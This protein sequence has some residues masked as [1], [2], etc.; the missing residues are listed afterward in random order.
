MACTPTPSVPTSVMQA[1][2]KY[3][4]YL[5][6]KE[7]VCAGNAL[8]LLGGQLLKPLLHLQAATLLHHISP[9]ACLN[10]KLKPDETRFRR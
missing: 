2:T 7:K 6:L 9:H 10:Q 3:I 1:E 5:V 4:A 8:K